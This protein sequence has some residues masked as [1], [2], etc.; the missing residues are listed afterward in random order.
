MLLNN[1]SDDDRTVRQRAGRAPRGF[2]QLLEFLL[3]DG[4]REGAAFAE[5]LLQARAENDKG[6]RVVRIKVRAGT[7]AQNLERAIG[8][9]C[10]TIRPIR[11]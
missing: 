1:R 4:F 10:Q 5:Q 2:Y 3:A 7:L 9:Q 11:G 8:R 6:M